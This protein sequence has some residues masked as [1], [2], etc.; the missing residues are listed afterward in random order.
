MESDESTAIPIQW[1]HEAN[2]IIAH[3]SLQSTVTVESSDHPIAEPDS[4]N[5]AT[6]FPLILKPPTPDFGHCEIK[7][8]FSR[9][10]CLFIFFYEFSNMPSLLVRCFDLHRIAFYC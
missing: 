8:M 5:T 3:G 6:K 9:P 1:S 10:V 7:S 4:E 2:W